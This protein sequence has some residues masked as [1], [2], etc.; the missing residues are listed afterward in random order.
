MTHYQFCVSQ[1]TKKAAADGQG[2]GR[3]QRQAQLAFY[4]S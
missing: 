1:N 2:G 4:F 3:V